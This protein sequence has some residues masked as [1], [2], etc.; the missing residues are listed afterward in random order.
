MKRP[1]LSA[2]VLI[3]RGE[4]VHCKKKVSDIPARDGKI[5]NLFL[6]CKMSWMY[7]WDGERGLE[8]NKTT[9]KKHGSL[10]TYSHY[11]WD[12]VFSRIVE[13][14]KKN[15][16]PKKAQKLFFSTVCS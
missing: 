7:S 12:R 10:P 6:Q 3:A 1:T 16:L 13:L 14:S 9:V 15:C 4:S 11:V 5:A 8:P 2:V